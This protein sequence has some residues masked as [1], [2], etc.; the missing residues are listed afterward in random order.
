MN[1]PG[2]IFR[3]TA[4]RRRMRAFVTVTATAAAIA[5][6]DARCPDCRHLIMAIP[7]EVTVEVRPVPSR[8]A[9]SGAGR[10]V[11]CGASGCR[12]WWEVIEHG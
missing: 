2:S 1:A 8:D 11:M 9:R 3:V 7:G 12:S 5:F 6:T 10:V 4:S